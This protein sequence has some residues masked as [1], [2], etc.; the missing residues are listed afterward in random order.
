MTPTIDEDDVRKADALGD[1]Y[2]EDGVRVDTCNEK[3]TILAHL[4]AEKIK[5]SA[6]SKLQLDAAISAATREGWRVALRSHCS[7]TGRHGAKLFRP[8]EPRTKS[9]ASK[10]H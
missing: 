7:E 5:L 1:E 2:R 4:V 8:L 3:D 6:F 9:R 10:G